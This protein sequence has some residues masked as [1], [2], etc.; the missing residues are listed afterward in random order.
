MRIGTF[1]LPVCLLASLS[2]AVP[3]TGCGPIGDLLLSPSPGSFYDGTVT[4]DDRKVYEDLCKNQYGDFAEGRT[5]LPR[6]W[7]GADDYHENGTWWNECQKEVRYAELALDYV[8][9]QE[10]GTWEVLSCDL[11]YDVDLFATAL[12]D[13]TVSV[14]NLKDGRVARIA[15]EPHERSCEIT[16]IS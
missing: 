11:S 4:D 3:L 9:E 6:R 15:V 5:T 8:T 12:E 16:D 1:W 13:V 14:R 10:G 2:I 7:D